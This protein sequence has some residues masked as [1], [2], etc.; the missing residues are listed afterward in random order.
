MDDPLSGPTTVS[1]DA[2]LSPLAVIVETPVTVTP[3]TVKPPPLSSVHVVPALGPASVSEPSPE[4]CAK[5]KP[6]NA[7]PVLWPGTE[8]SLHRR[9]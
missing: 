9:R 6:L 5:S 3:S 7:T 1:P 8:R 4:A 2:P